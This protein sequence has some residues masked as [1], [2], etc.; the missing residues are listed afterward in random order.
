MYGSIYSALDLLYTAIKNHVNVKKKT[1]SNVFKNG[2]S[3]ERRI[4]M[5]KSIFEV[6]CKFA[7]VIEKDSYGEKVFDKSDPP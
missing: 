2:T 3:C 5:R 1:H 4:I 7:K 6:S